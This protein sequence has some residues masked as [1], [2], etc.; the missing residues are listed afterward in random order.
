MSHTDTRQSETPFR[1][2][3][4]HAALGSAAPLCAAIH[5]VLPDAVLKNFVN[6]EMLQYANRNGGVDTKAKRMFARQV[7]LANESEVDLII[8]ACNIFAPFID[9]IIPFTDVPVITVDNSMQEKAAAIGGRIG[10]I[11]TN[12]SAVP[13]CRNG[14]LKKASAQGKTSIEFIDG[15]VTEAAQVLANGDTERFDQLIT[16]KALTLTQL[17]CDAI[18]L[19]QVTIARAKPALEKAGIA[20]PILTSP[21]ECAARVKQIVE[22]LQLRRREK[23]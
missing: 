3:L 19:A 5:Y 15:T 23:L 6:E 14:I 21:D 16:E 4:I 11:G 22:E 9:E 18:V 2:G 13:A 17:G 7:F 1:I 20:V 12:S 10:I 8:I